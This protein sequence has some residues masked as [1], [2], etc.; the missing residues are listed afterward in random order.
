MKIANL[1]KPNVKYRY[2]IGER[3]VVVMAATVFSTQLQKLRKAKGVKQEQ[4]AEHL[5]VSTQAVS[6]WE[7]G[8]YP[9]GDLLPQI[10][11]FFDVSIDYLYGN[12][13]KDKCLE[14][15]VRDY[16]FEKRWQKENGTGLDRIKNFI[17]AMQ[18][19][20]NGP[21]GQYTNYIKHNKDH[22]ISGSEIIFDD[23][24][25]YMRTTD[26]LEYY[27]MLQLPEE[28]LEKSFSDLAGIARVCRCFGTE[29]ALK[30]LFY[31][32]SLKGNESVRPEVISEQFGITVEKVKG[33]LEEMSTISQYCSFVGKSDL[34]LAGNQK[35]Q[36][37]SKNQAY[38]VQVL[39]ML[40]AA[41]DIVEPV[42]SWNGLCSTGNET[43]TDREKVMAMGGKKDE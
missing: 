23:G 3:M 22:C 24:F 4:L 34:L 25:S 8:S 27:A 30:I 16:L 26:D 43:W 20:M 40:A 17:W 21:E 32:M 41:K 9:D 18:C 36:I 29:E 7:N 37:Y 19:S 1:N 12:E 42:G 14:E 38:L 28:G 2:Y 15:Q 33:I 10:A 35:E 11:K 13:T 31:M 5:G 6:N 39:L